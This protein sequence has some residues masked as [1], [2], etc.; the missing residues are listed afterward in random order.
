MKSNKVQK[1]LDNHQHGW[2][3]VQPFYLDQDV[4]DAE[5][6]TIWKKYWLFAG[7]VAEI[8]KPGDYFLKV[9]VNGSDR[10]MVHLIKS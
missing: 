8:P 5:M 4:F 7:T 6:E 1:L 3:L 10:M 9:V 2:S